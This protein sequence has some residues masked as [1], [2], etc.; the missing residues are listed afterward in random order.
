[1]GTFQFFM[2]VIMILCVLLTLVVLSQNPKGGG[3]S[4]T[5][6]GGGGSQM[7]GVQRTNNFLD[8]TT[9]GLFAAV[10]ILVIGA[11][12]MQDNPN[13]IKIKTPAKQEIPTG[14]TTAPTGNTTVPTGNT[15][16]PAEAPAT[17][18]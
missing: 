10:I 18:K 9:W 13:A 2:V 8:R 3:L 11:N 4:S 16:A 14:N 12:V 6:G 7:F 5:F 15:T 1:M 17:T